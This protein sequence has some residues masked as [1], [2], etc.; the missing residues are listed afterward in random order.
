MQNTNSER[1][2]LLLVSNPDF[3]VRKG[4]NSLQHSQD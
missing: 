3:M 1:N 2:Q 4:L